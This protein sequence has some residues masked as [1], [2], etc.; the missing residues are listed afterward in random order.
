MISTS[1]HHVLSL[2]ARPAGA[3]FRWVECGFF[4]E[5]TE[6]AVGARR[7]CFVGSNMRR[8]INADLDGGAGE[9]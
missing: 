2:W 6:G 5:G 9:G 4:P 3:W 8:G 7:V 1:E